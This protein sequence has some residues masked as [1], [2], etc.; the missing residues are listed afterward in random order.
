M[1]NRGLLSVVRR[2][3][4]Y[5]AAAAVASGNFSAKPLATSALV[6]GAANGIGFGISLATGWHYHL[7]LIGTGIF[8]VFALVLRGSAGEPRQNASAACIALW[9]LKLAGFLFYRALQT[10][11]DARLDDVLSTI[12]GMF[13]FWFISFAWGWIV[14]S[15]HALAACVTT[16]PPFA[17]IDGLGLGI[18]AAGFLLETWA[19]WQ[20]WQ[21]KKDPASRGKFCNVGVWQLSQH[22]NWLGNFMLWS[23]IVVLNSSTLMAAGPAYFLP[24]LFSPLFLLGLFYGQACGAISN[25]VQLTQA[26]HGQDPEFQEYVRNVPLFFPTGGSIWRM[27]CG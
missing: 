4:G 22:P 2:A 1:L 12:P 18:F 14:S 11:T 19:D 26:K 16:R 6:F 23:G 25:T 20:K 9:A 13:G 17:W 7:D 10:H 8:S 15:P 21:F 27:V 3:A 5:S 24:S